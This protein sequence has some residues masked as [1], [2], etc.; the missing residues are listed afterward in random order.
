MELLTL[1]TIHKKKKING[2]APHNDVITN[3]PITERPQEIEL[4]ILGIFYDY[5][6]YLHES[7][8]DLGINNNLVSFS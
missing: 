6:V 3:K 7:E 8:F 1:L 5:V 4:R 2:Q